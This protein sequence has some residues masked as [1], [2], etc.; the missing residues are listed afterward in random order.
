M[1]FLFACILRTAAQATAS[2]G[3]ST[4]LRERVDSKKNFGISYTIQSHAL[5]VNYSNTR[6]PH[7]LY[8]RELHYV[9]E[10]CTR[11]S[12]YLALLSICWHCF[13]WLHTTS[14]LQPHPHFE[15]GSEFPIK[16]KGGAT[17]S[18]SSRKKAG[19]DA[20]QVIYYIGCV[21]ANTRP[22]QLHWHN[23][24]IYRDCYLMQE[25]QPTGFWL[26][27]SW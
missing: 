24:E 19:L 26:S 21:L 9:H 4:E 14:Y 1:Y 3:P 15:L 13:L 6:S 16:F 10:S 2:L 25:M 17:G 20:V 27:S 23:W 11:Q 12:T 18:V 22:H 8:D 7:N 5:M